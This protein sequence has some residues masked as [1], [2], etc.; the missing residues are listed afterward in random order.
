MKKLAALLL[1]F[2]AVI[3][4]S[5]ELDP[6]LT[7]PATPVVYALLDAEDSLA[8]V[9]LSKTFTLING[10]ETDLVPADSLRFPEARVWLE[11]WNGDYL[12]L[13]AELE[14]EDSP[15]E[16]GLF[17][18]A[19]NPVYNLALTEESLRIF[20]PP[21]HLD[22]DRIKLIV[23]IPGFPL[24]YSQVKPLPAPVFKSP[25]EGIKL[26]MF[27]D[28]GISPKWTSSP[29]VYY[30]EGY[31][32]IE[33]T[34][35]YDETDSL[36]FVRWREYHAD[37]T[38]QNPSPFI[39]Q[40]TDFLKRMAFYVGNDPQVRYRTFDKVW[41]YIH[42]SDEN[43]FEFRNRS[44]ISPIDQTG[45]PFSN[46]V[47]AIGLFSATATGKRFFY[48]DYYSLSQICNSEYTKHLRFVN[49]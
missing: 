18:S 33:Y 25:R 10:F 29:N 39:V 49:W 48:P 1:L 30:T 16:P 5:N 37:A 4:C 40:G 41:I 32:G 8:R 38:M 28:D 23:E 6:I 11:R 14:R 3:S 21:H 43:F 13:R 20:E 46:L 36:R 35:H 12:Y 7:G 24:I 31:I 17:P 42:C 15:R 44:G 47:N 27:G 19:P 34:D 9:K 22:I 26:G 45:L 2:S